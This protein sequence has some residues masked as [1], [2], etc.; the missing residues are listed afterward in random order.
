MLAKPE[1]LHQIPHTCAEMLHQL[2]QHCTVDVIGSMCSHLFGVGDS[3]F[4]SRVALLL[5]LQNIVC[6]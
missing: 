1:G 4:A 3:V 2:T 5:G 6:P